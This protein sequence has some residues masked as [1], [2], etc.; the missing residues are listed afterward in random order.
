MH[1]NVTGSFT[2]FRTFPIFPGLFR[3]PLSISLA[4]Q[5]LL[6]RWPPWITPVVRNRKV[7]SVG[8]DFVDV[9]QGSSVRTVDPIWEII[10]IGFWRPCPRRG[11]EKHQAKYITRKVSGCTAIARA[12]AAKFLSSLL[13]E[14]WLPSPLDNTH[15]HTQQQKCKQQLQSYSCSNN[16]G[17]RDR[18]WTI[19]ISNLS[20]LLTV[21]SN[22]CI[23]SCRYITW[24][25]SHKI[26][27]VAIKQ[28]LQY[29]YI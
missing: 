18:S 17:W 6:S 29:S 16:I 22:N 5:V 24:N 1:S 3:W 26:I 21:T 2:F 19:S 20:L 7:E 4:F 8:R 25:C 23:S 27:A 15:T 28:H 9:T 13:P 11:G 12:M 10:A 14:Y